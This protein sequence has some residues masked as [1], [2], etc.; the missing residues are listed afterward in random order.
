MIKS[1]L[2]PEWAIY[3]IHFN[4]KFLCWVFNPKIVFSVFVTQGVAIGLGYLLVFNQ[5]YPMLHNITPFST[6]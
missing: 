2:R 1:A 3:H 6:T 5:H 4:D